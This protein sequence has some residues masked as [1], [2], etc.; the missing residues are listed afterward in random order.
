MSKDTKSQTTPAREEIDSHILK[1]MVG[2]IA[3]SMPF[4]TNWLAPAPGL[5]SIS[6]SYWRGGWAQVVFIGFL[7][8]IA[9]FL[10]AYNGKNTMQMVLSKI[11][12]LAAICVALFPCECDCTFPAKPY[13]PPPPQPAPEVDWL[14]GT[15]TI[16]CKDP[17]ILVPHLHFV[18]AGLMFVI[19]AYFCY[20]FY[21]RALEGKGEPKIVSKEAKFRAGIYALCGLMIVAVIGA[22]SGD[23]LFAWLNKETNGPLVARWQTVIFW[24]EATG[25]FFFGVAWLVASRTL[26]LLTAGFERNS[27]SPYVKQKED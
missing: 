24:A 22:V 20:V 14:A 2:V 27:L 8:A 17:F 23:A 19:L 18:A 13:P 4:V 11:A 16:P 1:L 7:F 9:T 10:I 5:W 26:P 15:T 6:E 21:T 12:G 25:L 3:I